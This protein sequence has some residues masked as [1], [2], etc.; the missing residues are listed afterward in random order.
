[1]ARVE[2][3]VLELTAIV[4]PIRK[5]EEEQPGEDRIAQYRFAIETMEEHEIRVLTTSDL[6]RIAET[7]RHELRV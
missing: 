1:V 6:P 2:N 4:E 3:A 5:S 7:A